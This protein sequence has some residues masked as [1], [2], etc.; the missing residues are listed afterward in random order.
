VV[1][2]VAQRL[3]PAGGRARADRD[4]RLGL[5]TDLADPLGVVRRRD[6]ALDQRQVERP[7]CGVRR[8][9]GE[10][11]DV[12]RAGDRQQLVLAVEQA[13]LAAIA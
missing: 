9:L 6:R 5:R 7:G 1:A 4:Q 2:E 12:D 10:V 8:R 13:E 3:D 11:R